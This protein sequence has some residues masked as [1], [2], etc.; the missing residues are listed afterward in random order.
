MEH[1]EWAAI[2]RRVKALEWHPSGDELRIE[3]EDGDA[4]VIV[5][6]GGE[7]PPLVAQWWP[8]VMLEATRQVREL[9]TL[10]AEL[11]DVDAQLVEARRRQWWRRR[12]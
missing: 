8:R 12:P 10:D 6:G 9:L 7:L 1:E 2:G 4:L 5:A 3:F 11:Q